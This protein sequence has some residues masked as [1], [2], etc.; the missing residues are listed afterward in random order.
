MPNTIRF[1]EIGPLF[2]LPPITSRRHAVPRRREWNVAAPIRPLQTM[3]LWRTRVGHMMGAHGVRLI[4]GLSLLLLF[5]NLAQG[6]DVQ[7]G[8]GLVSISYRT[9][10]APPEPVRIA[11][12]DE[13]QMA[14]TDCKRWSTARRVRVDLD[15]DEYARTRTGGTPALTTFLKDLIPTLYQVAPPTYN[16]NQLHSDF[17]KYGWQEVQ[18]SHSKVGALIVWPGMA[19]VIIRDTSAPGERGKVKLP[20]LLVLYPSAQRSGQL[21]VVDAATLQASLSTTVPPRVIIP[22]P[23]KSIFWNTWV[24]DATGKEVSQH[25][26]TAGKSYSVMVDLSRFDYARV[27]KANPGAL[28]QNTRRYVDELAGRYG[29]LRFLVTKIGRGFSLTDASTT[30]RRLVRRESLDVPLP[31]G[32]AKGQAVG[33]FARQAT[34]LADPMDG[35]LKPV[36]VAIDAVEAACNAGIAFS[37]W[38]ASMTHLI[39]YVVRTV[40]ITDETGGVPRCIPTPGIAV[41]PDGPRLDMLSLGTFRPVTAS[42]SVFERQGQNDTLTV[43]VYTQEGLE[44]PYTWS[45]KSRLSDLEKHL[46][47][48]LDVRPMPNVYVQDVGG[49]IRDH[50]FNAQDN[51]EQE[52]NVAPALAALRELTKRS[53]GE[54]SLFARF[55]NAASQPVFIPIHLLTLDEN[56]SRPLGE[57]VDVIQA[58]PPPL[59]GSVPESTCISSLNIVI[60]PEVASV[61]NSREAQLGLEKM[62]KDKEAL[63]AAGV[64]VITEW[65]DFVDYVRMAQP[66]QQSEALLLLTHHGDDEIAFSSPQARPAVNSSTIRRWFRRL[67]VAVLAA[68]SVANISEAN[69]GRKILGT[70]NDRGVGTAIVSP[71]KV[72][73]AVAA[74]LIVAFAE[75]VQAA[76][77][78]GEEPTAETLFRQAVTDTEADNSL[79][80][81]DR[82]RVREFMLVGDGAVRFCKGGM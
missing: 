36:R 60:S 59:Y 43:V 26:L 4:T 62:R 65:A 16:T 52:M 24:E 28:D 42:L 57:Q 49:L 15:P 35:Q 2:L 81:G 9:C 67:S 5:P 74:R 72:D 3:G 1:Q 80:L 55:H 63:K 68:C 33:E 40:A 6:R 20:D 34:A 58:F 77:A 37:I 76:R 56:G 78:K 12:S 11:F 73:A 45:I 66:Q 23:K 53:A 31:R 82:I 47:T 18:P 7:P 19:G 41:A 29:E 14:V 30:L 54:R 22:I 48:Y 8:E 71:F 25:V 75:R 21:A 38:N 70:L 44:R 69:T 32:R 64:H 50:L 10:L 13:D 27:S 61:V 39:D 17:A 46:K 51:R 79:A